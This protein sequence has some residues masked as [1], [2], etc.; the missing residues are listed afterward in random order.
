[1]DATNLAY[2]I[3]NVAEVRC[4]LAAILSFHEMGKTKSFDWWKLTLE[5]N[6]IVDTPSRRLRS[7]YANPLLLE[8]FLLKNW[9][10]SW[11]FFAKIYF[12]IYAVVRLGFRKEQRIV[13]YALLTAMV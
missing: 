9:T 4:W 2:K 11:I 12:V 10:Y 8:F 6:L 7:S 3:W 1:M 5:I 13:G